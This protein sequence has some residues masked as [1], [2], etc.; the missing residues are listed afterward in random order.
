[1][2]TSLN[3]HRVLFLDFDGVV[4]SNRNFIIG[5]DFDIVALK[6][7]EKLQL[8]GGF[9]I[10]ISAAARITIKD[11]GKFRQT[12]IDDYGVTLEFHER[13]RTPTL[14]DAHLIRVDTNVQNYV[15]YWSKEMSVEIDPDYYNIRF[16]R[17]FQ[18]QAWL[19]AEFDAVGREMD[20]L[21]LDDS[22]DMFPL[23]PKSVILVKK[24]E[25]RGGMQLRHYDKI[26]G[27]FCSGKPPRKTVRKTKNSV[28]N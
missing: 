28:P 11:I 3:Q 20:Y 5:M 23:K 15:K 17:G 21:V 6:M 9:K 22:R 13:W 1:M 27:Y 10:V 16:W 25:S 18:I 7:I 12:L 4:R 26:R 24:G 19:N 2:S 14:K 8:A